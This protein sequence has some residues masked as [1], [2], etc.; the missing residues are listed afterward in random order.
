MRPIALLALVSAA[1][2]ACAEDGRVARGR[3]F[4]ESRCAECHAVGPTGDS[5]LTGAPAFRVEYARSFADY[6]RRLM[7]AAAKDL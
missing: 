5:P 2:A 6:V 4:V 7:A 1:S 3:A